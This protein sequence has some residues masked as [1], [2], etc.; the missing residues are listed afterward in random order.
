MQM[1]SLVRP[2]TLAILA[3]VIAA[4]CGLRNPELVGP[5]AK[6]TS[7]SPST[8]AFEFDGALVAGAQIP[9]DAP[10]TLVVTL[11]RRLAAGSQI[12]VSFPT[13]VQEE[14]DALWSV[15]TAEPGHPGSIR[16]GGSA[17]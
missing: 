3:V 7:S 12:A 11:G 4:G 10:L 17:G 15:P 2:R 14:T 8:A 13:A 6:P 1:R 5:G 16:L 9:D